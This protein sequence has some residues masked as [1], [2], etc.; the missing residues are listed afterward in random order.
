MCALSRE[1]FLASAPSSLGDILYE[2]LQILIQQQQQQHSSSN[3]NNEDI[4]SMSS[5]SSNGSA[6]PTSFTFG[7]T[8]TPPPPPP[9]ISHP[10]SM[11]ATS[12][13]FCHPS[14]SATTLADQGYLPPTTAYSAVVSLRKRLQYIIEPHNALYSTVHRMSHIVDRTLSSQGGSLHNGTHNR[15]FLPHDQNKLIHIVSAAKCQHE[16]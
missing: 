2:H 1:A 3:N 11:T 9:P 16:K 5:R 10:Y 4:L 7:P 13:L 6:S 14:F 15:S 8:T 12:S